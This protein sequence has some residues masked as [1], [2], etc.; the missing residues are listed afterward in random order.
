MARRNKT[1]K[2]ETESKTP[3]DNASVPEQTSEAAPTQNTTASREGKENIGLANKEV[4]H[5]ARQRPRPRHRATPRPEYRQFAE[6]LKAAMTKLGITSSELARQ[7][8]GTMQDKRGYAVARN[9]DRIG[10]YLAGTSYPEDE[11]LQKL[12]DA[13]GLPVETLAIE[14]PPGQAEP[15]EGAATPRPAS[16]A[17][18]RASGL[19]LTTLPRDATSLARFQCDRMISPALAITIQ[20][21]ILDDAEKRAVNGPA[22][23]NGGN[24]GDNGNNKP[25]EVGSVIEGRERSS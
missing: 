5:H 14:R 21:M 23:A 9:R 7:I 4:Q 13:L 12:A 3:L 8:W 16:T 11:N 15:P 19:V 22:P 1:D 6:T 18:G 20:Q 24:N 2:P 25:P 17:Q 10:H